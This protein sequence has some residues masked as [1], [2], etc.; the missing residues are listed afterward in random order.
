MTPCNPEFRSKDKGKSAPNVFEEPIILAT[1]S[2]SEEKI[3]NFTR[4]IIFS[5]KVT[6]N[7]T[8]RFCTVTGA[9]EA[10]SQGHKHPGDELVF[11]LDGGTLNFSGG[12]A[13]A[14]R[15]NQAIAI[16]PN[17]EHKTIVTTTDQWQGLSFYC[18]DCPLMNRIKPETNTNLVRKSVNNVT[19]LCS[20]YLENQSIFSPALKE[21]S[22]MELYILSSSRDV[23]ASEFMHRGETVYYVISGNVSISWK[24][25]NKSLHPQMAAA[26][27]AG[28]SHQ[29]KPEDADG[30]RLI[31]ASCSSCSMLE[32]NT[33]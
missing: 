22:F 15:Q 25:K 23:S 29:L 27:P 8:I 6:E 12:M 18:D 13:F 1:C 10:E 33:Y 30:C 11:T 5:P 28:F 9:Y 21:S 24:H 17:I 7:C 32:L 14:Q 26:I 2:I 16:P 4:R 19:K 20:K 31:A 3:Y